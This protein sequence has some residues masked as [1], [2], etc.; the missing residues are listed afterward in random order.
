M[1]YNNGVTKIS[2]PQKQSTTKPRANSDKHNKSSQQN[3]RSS[4]QQSQ[5]RTSHQ[6]S[7]SATSLSWQNG[8]PSTTL[9]RQTKSAADKWSKKPSRSTNTLPRPGNNT[10][11]ASK[12]HGIAEFPEILGLRNCPHGGNNS[13]DTSEH[14]D[15]SPGFCNECFIMEPD[16]INKMLLSQLHEDMVSLSMSESS[17]VTHKS[18][19]LEGDTQVEVTD[20]DSDF[21]DSFSDLNDHGDELMAELSK[22]LQDK[23]NAFLAPPAPGSG[24]ASLCSQQGTS[25]QCLW[26]SGPSAPL[27][28]K[29][30]KAGEFR[31]QYNKDTL[32]FNTVRKESIL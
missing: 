19:P 28:S 15:T 25:Y 3:G 2:K 18:Q 32:E 11:P 21:T 24:S 27:A 9:P 14:Y 26:K 31:V 1:N 13:D 17:R 8:L 7:V 16:T 23:N 4:K 12:R 10:K 29:P 30:L 20:S 5:S 6:Q 22:Q